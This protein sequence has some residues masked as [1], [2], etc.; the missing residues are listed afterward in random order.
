MLSPARSPPKA[1]EA[2]FWERWDTGETEHRGD[3]GEHVTGMG[4]ERSETHAL[5]ADGLDVDSSFPPGIT[6]RSNEIHE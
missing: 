5:R 6:V 3:G 1:S 2:G 4:D